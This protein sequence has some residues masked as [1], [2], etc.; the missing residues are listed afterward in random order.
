MTRIDVDAYFAAERDAVELLP[1]PPGQYERVRSAARRRRARGPVIA[2]SVAAVVAVA[3]LVGVGHH[4]PARHDAT[5][6]RPLPTA[7]GGTV[8]PGAAPRHFKPMAVSF[9]SPTHGFALGTAPCASR[10][11]CASVVETRDGGRTW[12]AVAAP[13]QASAGSPGNG[14]RFLDNRIGWIYGSGLW[15][16]ADG[17]ATWRRQS[18]GAVRDLAV[19]VDRRR[20]YVLAGCG[21]GAEP[22]CDPAMGPIVL[23]T[24]AGAP[25]AGWTPVT[26]QQAAQ[27]PDPDQPGYRLLAA[28]PWLYVVR[29]RGGL[30]AVPVGPVFTVLPNPEW[31]IEQGARDARVV[32]LD[33]HGPV[34]V[35]GRRGVWR[36][37]DAGRLIKVG[38]TPRRPGYGND[39][40]DALPDAIAVSGQR[41]VAAYKLPGGP[42]SGSL[43]VS[44]DGGRTW[45]VRVG[46]PLGLVDVQLLGR[47]G[48]A[49]TESAAGT[50]YFSSDGGEHWHRYRFP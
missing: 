24:R 6:P 49:L 46:S 39:T 22:A 21:A 30:V 2:A 25:A 36:V 48:V 9:V 47:F 18:A 26:S 29:P 50:M 10:V 42:S 8:A 32:T 13:A 41:I 20:A 1:A 19:D 38:T 23:G 35:D 3:A 14:I 11:I 4:G 45:I 31:I 16:T 5:P 28:Y 27:L 7:P 34:V 40:V 37:G 33:R 44:D 17:G 43:D 15:V 12:R